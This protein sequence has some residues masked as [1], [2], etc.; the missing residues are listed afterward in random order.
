M[1]I[2]DILLHLLDIPSPTKEE[3]NVVSF[4]RE[5]IHQHS[6]P[7]QT[8]EHDDSLMISF[9]EAPSKKHLSFVGHTDVIPKFFKP[10]IKENLCHGAGASDMKGALAV[11]LWLIQHTLQKWQS[12]FNLSFIFYAREENTPLKENGLYSLIQQFPNF[13][14]TIDLAIV[15]EP[16]DNTVQLGCMGSLHATITV[17]GQAC[18]SAR[19]W[20]GK[21]ALYE[22]LPL[23]SFFAKQNPEKKQIFGVDFFDVATLTEAKAEEGKTSVP[24]EMTFNLNYRFSPLSSL[25]E[26]TKQIHH[27]ASLFENTTWIITDSVYPGKVIQTPFF[28]STIQTLKAPIGAKQA[29]TDVAQLTQRNIPAFNFGP[30]KQ[31]QAHQHHEHI[32]LNDIN[33]HI[34]LL[35]Q[36]L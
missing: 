17:H 14:D 11:Y 35:E 15:G 5:T 18:H 1:S 27:W 24:G 31:S 30:G 16:T 6:T 34:Q 19:P 2:H 36:L 25:E 12:K 10:Y 28:E 22:S 26:A 32:D 3:K 21:N 29:W 33:H 8:F 20:Q 9:G 13:F 4:L 23:I 7:S